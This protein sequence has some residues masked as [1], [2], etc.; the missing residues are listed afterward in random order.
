[1]PCLLI[2]VG[3]LESGG[4]FT[5]TFSYVVNIS[6]VNTTGPE[7]DT[8]SVSANSFPGEKSSAPL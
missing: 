8:H 1:V 4:L 6:V 5:D 7:S 3:T 2:D